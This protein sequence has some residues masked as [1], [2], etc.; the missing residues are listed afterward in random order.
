MHEKAI[1]AESQVGIAIEVDNMHVQ[2][3]WCPREE[4]VQQMRVCRCLETVALIQ[5]MD[6]QRLKTCLVGWGARLGRSK[7]DAMIAEAF[8]GEACHCVLQALH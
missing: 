3:L 2:L 8:R 1:C 4:Q 5:A 6:I 7:T